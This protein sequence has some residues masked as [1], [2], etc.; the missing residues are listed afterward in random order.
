M[1]LCDNVSLLLKSPLYNAAGFMN[2]RIRNHMVFTALKSI[3]ADNLIEKY[4]IKHPLGNITFYD[5]IMI[6]IAKW[7]C[8]K[9][10]VFIFTDPYSIYDN[11]SENHFSKLLGTLQGLD[12]SLLLI[13]GSEENL[14]KFCTRIINTES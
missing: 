1:N 11:L 7:L 14:S 12:I 6:E 3:Q 8:L 4:G 2:M 9:P 10:K 13:S 5:Q